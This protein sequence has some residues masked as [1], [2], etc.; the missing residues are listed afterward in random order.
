[1]LL[2]AHRTPT[3]VEG[4]AE[5]AEAGASIFECDVQLRG[6]TVMVSHYLPFLNLTGWFQHDN[7]HFR[8]RYGPPF[9]PTLADV[10]ARIPAD[11]GILLDPKEKD[12]ARCQ[13]LVDALVAELGTGPNGLDRFRASTGDLDDLERYR[14]A[15]FATWRTLKSPAEIDA[16][17]AEGPMPHQGVSVRQTALDAD[18]IDR[19][20]GVVDTIVAWTVNDPER[21]RQLA[22][23]GVDGITTDRRDVMQTVANGRSDRS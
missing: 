21:A 11:C 19:L 16:A 5:L 20:H 12:P 17:V 15:G 10:L 8:W 3:T 23:S 14:A 1:V 22:D 2:V 4:C 9:D 13:A 7:A 18:S 6:D